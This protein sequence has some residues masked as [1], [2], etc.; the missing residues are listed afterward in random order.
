MATRL[1]LN[2]VKLRFLACFFF[3]LDN[4]HGDLCQFKKVIP[5]VTRIL[6]A[7]LCQEPCQVTG[8]DCSRE[9]LMNNLVV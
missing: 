8:H 1:E 9:V 2:E 5:E 4:Q 7:R 6:S 3:L